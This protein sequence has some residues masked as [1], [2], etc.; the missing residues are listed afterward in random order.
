VGCTRELVGGG[1]SGGSGGWGE[2]GASGEL[3]LPSYG[4]LR[5][6]IKGVA[7]RDRWGR[8]ILGNQHTPSKRTNASPQCQWGRG[9]RVGGCLSAV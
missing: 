2:W 3:A 4:I 9:L 8:G 7:G 1:G 5:G 6:R